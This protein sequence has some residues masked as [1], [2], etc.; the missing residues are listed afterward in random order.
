MFSQNPNFSLKENG[1]RNRWLL[2]TLLQGAA[3]T[4]VFFF[5][6]FTVI[7][8]NIL[9]G[10]LVLLLLCAPAA[11]RL[12]VMHHCVYKKHGIKLLTLMMIWAPLGVLSEI[13]NVGKEGFSPLLSVC[14]GIDVVLSTFW[15]VLS[16][17]IRAI[18]RAFKQRT[19]LL[20]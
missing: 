4:L 6:G 5:V 11:L 15:F 3:A 14:L 20:T 13:A 19:T 9:L 18:N 1:I 16:L 8:D 17:K 10:T 7:L 2:L 12:K